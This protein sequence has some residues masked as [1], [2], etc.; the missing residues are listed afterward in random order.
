MLAQA[1]NCETVAL[2]GAVE[3]PVD[4]TVHIADG[5][6]QLKVNNAVAL[7]ADK[8]WM[9]ADDSVIALLSVYIAYADNKPVLNQ[10]TKV[11]VYCA[12]AQLRIIGLELIV[13]HLSGGVLMAGTECI[14][15]SLPLF[16]VLSCRLY[17]YQL[18]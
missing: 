15:Q 3:L 8:V 13:Q 1:V 6:R 18:L 17:V 16:A 7:A 11:A 10:H 12:E 2:G 14:Q 9:G 5:V 4:L